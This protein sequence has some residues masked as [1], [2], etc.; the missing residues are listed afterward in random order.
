MLVIDFFFAKLLVVVDWLAITY[1]CSSVEITVK[2]AGQLLQ[3]PTICL[4]KSR[5]LEATV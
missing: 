3:G 1:V 5:E 4:H 2:P